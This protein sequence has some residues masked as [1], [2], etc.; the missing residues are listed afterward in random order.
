MCLQSKVHASTASMAI[1]ISWSGHSKA[2][3]T[4][5]TRPMKEYI[6][7]IGNQSLGC[8][9]KAG[10][11]NKYQ[12][13]VDRSA[14]ALIDNWH[15]YRSQTL[16]W[17]EEN[18]LWKKKLVFIK[19]ICMLRQKLLKSPVEKILKERPDC[20]EKGSRE[21]AQNGAARKMTRTLG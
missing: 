12:R 11:G 5:D 2:D 20:Q 10:I 1:T 3:W 13:E 16:G 19:R 4:F 14:P 21:E 18:I 6:F 9:L 8:C 15:Q 7:V 17:K